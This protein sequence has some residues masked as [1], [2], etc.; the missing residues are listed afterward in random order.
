ML[1]IL[2]QR[3]KR[4]LPIPCQ[5]ELSNLHLKLNLCVILSAVARRVLH[6]HKKK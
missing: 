3:A 1:K 4:I 6:T 5:T 2:L